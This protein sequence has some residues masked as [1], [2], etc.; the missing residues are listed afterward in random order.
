[1]VLGLTNKVAALLGQDGRV[2]VVGD[3]NLM[4][5]ALRTTMDIK[6][7][8][9]QGDETVNR[10]K[11]GSRKNAVGLRGSQGLMVGKAGGSQAG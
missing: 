2:Y 9:R 5:R 4:Q 10:T 8:W 7:S 3:V 6:K 11:G 1:M